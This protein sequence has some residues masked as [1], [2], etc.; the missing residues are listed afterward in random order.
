MGLFNNFLNKCVAAETLTDINETAEERAERETQEKSYNEYKEKRNKVIRKDILKDINACF[1]LLTYIKHSDTLRELINN[2]E[3][4]GELF[5]IIGTKLSNAEEDN[6]DSDDLLKQLKDS[7]NKLIEASQIKSSTNVDY[8]LNELNA[9]D[10]LYK[11][12]ALN[13]YLQDSQVSKDEDI[14]LIQ[15]FNNLY[16]DFI[17]F[18]AG[19]L[20]HSYRKDNLS[21]DEK[22]PVAMELL[23]FSEIVDTQIISKLKNKTGFEEFVNNFKYNQDL[24]TYLKSIF[25]SLKDDESKFH[26]NSEYVVTIATLLFKLKNLVIS[27]FKTQTSQDTDDSEF[28]EEFYNDLIDA[29]SSKEFFKK[30]KLSLDM[31]NDSQS[32]RQFLLETLYNNFNLNTMSKYCDK[33]VNSILNNLNKYMLQFKISNLP[34]DYEAKIKSIMDFGVFSISLAGAARFINSHD[35]FDILQSLD[36]YTKSSATVA[37]VREKI[38]KPLTSLYKGLLKLIKPALD[39][40]NTLETMPNKDIYLTDKNVV[41]FVFD[42]KDA[43]NFLQQVYNQVNVQLNILNELPVLDKENVIVNDKYSN[44][45][46]E[47]GNEAKIEL[48]D[49]ILKDSE[50]ID[51]KTTVI[52]LYEWYY[53]EFYNNYKNKFDE[54]NKY[55]GNL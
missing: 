2:C 12:F 28:T 23:H 9:G 42:A 4:I 3:S 17:K 35:I 34:E 30:Y 26:V 39:C 15:E 19:I 21:G 46:S 38:K 37:D 8:L 27:L 45:K 1:D 47:D 13:S 31:S 43:L 50:I 40:K 24:N 16:S 44:E 49:E 55:I 52:K 36:F 41:D 25:K 10:T 7:L 33:S 48:K 22:D 29:V 14:S 20:E 6:K 5:S 54:Y 32:T 53:K 18:I 11:F 51:V